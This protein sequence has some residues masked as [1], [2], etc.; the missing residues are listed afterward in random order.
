MG[1]RHQEDRYLRGFRWN[2]D[3]ETSDS[4]LDGSCKLRADYE[5]DFDA[6]SGT[7]TIVRTYSCVDASVPGVTCQVAQEIIP[8]ASAKGMQVILGVW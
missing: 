2:L 3:G 7:G 1:Y 8:A 5:A 4:S 6:L